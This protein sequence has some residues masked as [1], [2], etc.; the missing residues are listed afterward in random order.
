MNSAQSPHGLSLHY[1]DTQDYKI[2]KQLSFDI[3]NGAY[4]GFGYVLKG[5]A[6]ITIKAGTQQR[7]A[8]VAY[9]EIFYIPP[10]CVCTIHNSDKQLAQVIQI[11]FQFDKATDA[12]GG[13]PF[14][15]PASDTPSLRFYRFRMPRAAAGSRICFKR[16]SSGIPSLRFTS[17]CSRIFTPSHRNL[18]PYWRSRR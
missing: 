14:H 2:E 1:L 15:A 11:R 3:L 8:K 4:A 6:K 18:W 12:E 9:G 5:S 17:R 13:S 16:G 7:T 10:D